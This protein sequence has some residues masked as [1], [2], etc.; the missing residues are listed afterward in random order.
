VTAILFAVLEKQIVKQLEN[1][2]RSKVEKYLKKL[3]AFQNRYEY[4]R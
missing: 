3:L 1:I 4:N 2:L